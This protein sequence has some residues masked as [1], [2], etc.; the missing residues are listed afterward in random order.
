M[1]AGRCQRSE[2]EGVVG[3]SAEPRD[4]P[5]SRNPDFRNPAGVALKTYNIASTH[6]AYRAR[7]ATATGWTRRCLMISSPILPGCMRWRPGSASC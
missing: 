1:A 7:R 6:P 4:S 5:L 3:S 2:G